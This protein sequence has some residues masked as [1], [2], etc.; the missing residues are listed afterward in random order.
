MYE[1][2]GNRDIMRY[3]HHSVYVRDLR[4]QEKNCMFY[5]PK[6]KIKEIESL[7]TV[8]W[9]FRFLWCEF[10]QKILIK[11]GLF[12]LRSILVID[13]L[14]DIRLHRVGSLFIQSITVYI[15]QST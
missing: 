12:L 13:L 5:S 15:L 9:D 14:K 4:L 2:F 3:Y 10:N 11:Y 6:K 8:Q 7:P 1:K